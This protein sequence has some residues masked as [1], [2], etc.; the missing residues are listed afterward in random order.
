MTTKKKLS[1]AERRAWWNSLSVEDQRL[2][3]EY[4]MEKRRAVGAL[5][6]WQV[7]RAERVNNLFDT[8]FANL[9]K[10]GV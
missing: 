8:E 6:T 10:E 2:Y 7:W 3:V 5:P 9:F 4:A 1:K